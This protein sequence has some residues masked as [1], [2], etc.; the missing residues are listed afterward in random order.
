[1]VSGWPDAIKCTSASDGERV[2]YLN[3]APSS[4]GSYYYMEP[5]ATSGVWDA[6]LRY[7]ASGAYM[8]AGPGYST[9][10]CNTSIANIYTAGRAFNFVGGGGGSGVTDG[11]KGD[12]TVS[13]T[14]AT[15]TVDDGAVAYDDIQ[16]VSAPNKLL[17][18]YTTGT[19]IV[20][21][22]AIG[23]GLTLSSGTLSASG[24]ITAVTTASCSGSGCVA[25]CPATYFRTGCSNDFM[26]GT[27]QPAAPSGA[28]GCT[29]SVGGGA[30]YCYA[31]CAK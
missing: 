8:N 1:M 28:D 12:I 13:G 6:Y 16:N 2:L 17:G 10:N 29:C 18:R 19:G 25:T 31:Y 27:A 15:W 20:E 4:N 3:N 23:S 22:I 7:D 26:G 9:T 11:D 24:G 14:G 30:Y 21:E 5:W